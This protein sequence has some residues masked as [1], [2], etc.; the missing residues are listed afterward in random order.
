MVFYTDGFP[1]FADFVSEKLTSK[2]TDKFILVHINLRNYYYLY[3]DEKLRENIKRSCICVFDGIGMKAGA[4][5]RGYE[6]LPDLN[7]TDLFPLLMKKFT[8]M[9]CGIFLLGADNHIIKETFKKIQEDFTGINICGHRSGYFTEDEENGVVEE[10]NKS[11][12]DILIIGRGFPLQEEFV[13]KH[14]DDLKVSFIWNVG[15]L[16]DIYSGSKPRA[17]KVLRKIRLEWLYRFILEPGRMFHRN[18]VAA[19]WSLFHVAFNIK[20]IS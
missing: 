15:G 11:N 1:G 17:P 7:G 14:K 6:A 5:L 20:D 10:I 13:I 8:Y 9:K 2:S 18:T 3:K 19:A 16:F 4:M 12:S